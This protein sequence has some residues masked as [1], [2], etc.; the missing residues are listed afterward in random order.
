MKKQVVYKSLGANEKQTRNLP[1][2]K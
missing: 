2:S 1:A